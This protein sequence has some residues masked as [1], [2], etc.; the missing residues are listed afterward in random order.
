LGASVDIHESVQYK[1]IQGILTGST[2][3]LGAASFQYGPLSQLLHVKWLEMVGPISVSGIRSAD[4]ARHFAAIIFFITV[5]FTFLRT[6]QAVAV[7]VG[8]MLFFPTMSLFHFSSN[9]PTGLWGWANLWRYAGLYLISL[10]LPYITQ[11]RSGRTRFGLLAMLGGAW[12]VTTLMAQENLTGG[13][14][15]ALAIIC[16]L[17]L[18]R[19]CTWSGALVGLAATGAGAVLVWLIYLSP[20]LLNGTAGQFLFNYASPV[21]MVTSGYSNTPWTSSGYDLLFYSSPILTAIIGVT[22]ALV[23]ARM[24]WVSSP[25]QPLLIPDGARDWTPVFGLFCGAAV[26]QAGVLTRSDWLHLLNSFAL[27]PMLIA[28]FVVWVIQSGVVLRRPV[29]MALA[30][31]TACM[32]LVAVQVATSW[33]L[34]PSTLTETI[35]APARARTINAQVLPKEPIPRIDAQYMDLDK[36]VALAGESPQQTAELSIE[37]KEF[38]GNRVTL[39]DPEMA[40]VFG[41]QLGY[42]YFIADL[43]PYEIPYEELSVAFTKSLVEANLKSIFDLDEPLCGLITTKPNAPVS[44]AALARM[45]LTEAISLRYHD[46][47]VMAYRCTDRST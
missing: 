22:V 47:D 4:L 37:L 43:K 25:G 32:S 12:A 8:A 15:T 46:V 39:I 21:M 27:F 5:S 6:K 10:G 45:G 44:Q 16:G 1:G 38:L 30:I 36:S 14:I 3:Y 31:A 42:L 34:Q 33:N 28:L 2:P 41:N 24:S 20:Y 23:A 19:R 7:C 35:T 9:G 13:V 11:M 29:G 17:T 18:A 40:Y 26:A